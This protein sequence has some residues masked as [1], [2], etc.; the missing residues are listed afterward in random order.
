MLNFQLNGTWNLTKIT[1]FY[2]KKVVENILASGGYIT[3]PAA[4]ARAQTI[5]FRPPSKIYAGRTYRLTARST[6]TLP[7]TLAVQDPSGAAS[8]VASGPNTVTLKVNKSGSIG[9]TAVQP[10]GATKAGKAFL[11]ATPVQSSIIAVQR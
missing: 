11:P 7:V 6:S 4:L 9:V 5:S 2:S 3:F 8:I 1:P 10:G